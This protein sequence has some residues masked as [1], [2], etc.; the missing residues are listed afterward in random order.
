MCRDNKSFISKHILNICQVNY[1]D[2]TNFIYIINNKTIDDYKSNNILLK[3]CI[4][5][6]EIPEF[7]FILG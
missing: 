6:Y 4:S 5:S 2:P 3:L 1:K 7:G